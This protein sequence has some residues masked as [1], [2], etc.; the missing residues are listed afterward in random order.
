LLP[1]RR[2]LG[3]LLLGGPRG[4][5]R[6]G[7]DV[8]REQPRLLELLLHEGRH[9][10]V[11]V[12]VLSVHDEDFHLV[13]GLE[14]RG[15]AKQDTRGQRQS[16]HEGSLLCLP[17]LRNLSGCGVF[18]R[19]TSLIQEENMERKSVVAAVLALALS[20]GVVLAQ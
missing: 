11:V 12:V 14:P 9:R 1:V 6:G 20:A 8:D 2:L 7:G 13:L 16:F 3:R 5:R 4:G 19:L 17:I 18:V 10:L 15:G